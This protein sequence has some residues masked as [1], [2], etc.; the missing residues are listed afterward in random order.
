MQYYPYPLTG[1]SMTVQAW[2]FPKQEIEVQN[3]RV[4]L[5]LGEEL[6]LGAPYPAAAELQARS[7]CMPLRAGRSE[8]TD[9]HLLCPDPF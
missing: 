8:C 7:L 1:S 6:G 5:C 9:S 4:P 3:T 2:R